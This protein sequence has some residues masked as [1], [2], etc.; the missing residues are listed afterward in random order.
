M[1]TWTAI[2]V[3]A[4]GSAVVLSDGGDVP[5]NGFRT[6]GHWVYNH[7]VGAV[8]HIDGGTKNIDAKVSDVPPGGNGGG[9]ITLQGPHSGFVVRADGVVVFGTPTLRVDTTIPLSIPEAPVGLE[10]VG[11]PYLVYRQAG[12]AVRLSTQPTVVQLGGPVSDPVALAD[13]TIWVRRTDT[14]AVCRL[15]AAGVTLHCPAT[16]PT[17]DDAVLAVIGDRPAL[18]R[19]STSSVYAVTGDGLGPPVPLGVTIPPDAKI[20]AVDVDGRLPILDPG[21]PA[22]VLANVGDLERAAVAMPPVMVKLTGGSYGVPVSG[23]GSVAVIDETRGS[24]LVFGPDGSR[25]G[26]SPV[27]GGASGV[28]VVRGEDRRLYL[29]SRTGTHTLVIDP[30]G[31]VTTVP[32]RGEAPTPPSKPPTPPP[33]APP[34]PPT[35]GPPALPGPPVRVRAQAGDAVATIT[36]G[37]AVANRSPI[38]GYGIACRDAGGA[39]GPSTNVNGRQLSVRLAGFAN[40]VAY[41]CSV[42]AVNGVG[43]GPAADSPTFT[44]SSDVPGAPGQVQATAAA[45]GTVAV[46]WG[47]ANGQ[48]H[49]I[50]RYDVTAAGNDGSTASVAETPGTSVR[51]S[52]LTLG[53]TYRFTVVATNDLGVTGPASA[54]SGGV[55]PYRPADAPTGI[56][57]TPGDG[58]ISLTWQPANLN[59]GQLVHYLVRVTGQPDRTV[60][61]GPVQYTGLTNGTAYQLSVAAVTRPRGGGQMLTGAPAGT[62]ATP[63]TTATADVVGVD[64]TGDRQVTVHLV[65]HLNN[66][67]PATCRLIF[68]GVLRWSGACANDITVGGL[69]YATTY[70][71]YASLV[72][73]YGTGGTGSHGSVTTNPP[74]RLATVSRGRPRPPDGQCSGSACAFVRV[75]LS[76]YPPGRRVSVTCVS[77]GP[78]GGSGSFYT[79]NATIDGGGRSTTEVCF[80]GYT[81]QS[82][83]VVAD[84]VESNHFVW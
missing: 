50:A 56:N 49:T 42:T 26:N 17:G 12:T 71:I 24:I 74:P 70:D 40:G 41:I 15:D 83:W 52:G 72:N 82:V 69:E 13:G 75:D 29:D 78:N 47:A 45:D 19:R 3:L 14:G 5:F 59:G 30:D 33:P 57:A 51:V 48:G 28:Q 2:A 7:T 21:T 63:G 23:D 16:G 34:K 54:E 46:S 60:P 53:V 67:G 84:G 35:G 64:L 76:N 32:I 27:P 8:F 61:G 18:V 25:R 58:S 1:A 9:T 44:P 65:L 77:S 81:R 73:A 11:G 6:S 68:N 79:Y 22:L 4:V 10:I 43:R 66:S 20:G 39:A 31:S 38:T 36:W 62:T 55:T 37:A 80:Y